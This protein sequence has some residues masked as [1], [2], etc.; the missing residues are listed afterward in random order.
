MNKQ[1]RIFLFT[2]ILL[3][4]VLFYTKVMWDGQFRMDFH[5]PFELCNFMQMWILYAVVTNRIKL[6]DMIMYPAILGPIAALSYPFGIA[7]IGTFYLCYFMFYH[8][9]LI[10]VGL[11][12]LV[13]RKANVHKNDLFHSIIFMIV[14]AVF[15]FIANTFTG[16]NYMFLSKRIFPTPGDFNY[17]IFLILFTLACLCS[18]HFTIVICR[19]FVRN[20]KFKYKIH[21]EET[22]ASSKNLKLQ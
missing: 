18:F 22:N 17:Q 2:A 20:R 5:L 12:R 1:L 13:Q 4:W 19:S 11:F 16:G 3:G 6:L 10:F 7:S 21:N 14:S 15:A 9:T 8:L